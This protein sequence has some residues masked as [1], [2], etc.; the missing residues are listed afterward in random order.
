ME[1]TKKKI[2]FDILLQWSK[3]QYFDNYNMTKA[4]QLQPVLGKTLCSGVHQH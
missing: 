2:I 1:T 3:S 4:E